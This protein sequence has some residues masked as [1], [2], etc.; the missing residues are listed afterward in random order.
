[1]TASLVNSF[2][3]QWFSLNNVLHCGMSGIFQS[4]LSLCFYDSGYNRLDGF[5]KKG[6]QSIIKVCRKFFFCLVLK[7]NR[8]PSK[9][10]YYRS[11][12]C[13]IRLQS[14]TFHVCKEW[15]LRPDVIRSLCE[16]FSNFTFTFA[17]DGT[18]SP[19]SVVSP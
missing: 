6:F 13:K 7:W 19:I 17:V 8:K 5:S 4:C 15:G 2:A 9:Q 16:M 1:M 14:G 10:L 11:R 18:M 12:S 3:C